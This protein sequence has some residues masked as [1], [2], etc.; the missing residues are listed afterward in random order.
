MA[1]P[2][3]LLALTTS[4]PPAE[5]A[6]TLLAKVAAAARFGVTRG[7]CGTGCRRPRRPRRS[8]GRSRC[9]RDGVVGDRDARERERAVEAED[10]AAEAAALLAGGG[11]PDRPLGDAAPGAVTGEGRVG[12][13]HGPALT[14]D[15]AAQARPAAAGSPFPPPLPPPKP[16]KPPDPPPAP[17]P[18]P[19]RP[20]P[21]VAAAEAAGPASPAA[22][23]VSA[24]GL[25][26]ESDA[27]AG[28]PPP[29]PGVAPVATPPFGLPSTADAGRRDDSPPPPWPNSTRVE[30]PAPP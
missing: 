3:P 4:D 16:A 27:A 15:R 10:R 8:P 24:L 26:P 21:A 17:P 20:E 13:D 7:R 9:R 1:D 25:R 29:K 12:G 23:V 11:G 30:P 5:P 2:A 6:K 18:P 14:E 22:A 28:P 19:A